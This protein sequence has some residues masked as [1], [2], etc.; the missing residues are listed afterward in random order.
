MR[1]AATYLLPLGKFCASDAAASNASSERRDR[2][3]SGA[4]LRCQLHVSGE[5]E[6]VLPPLFFGLLAL[7][8]YRPL[9]W[10]SLA[11]PP[12]LFAPGLDARTG[13]SL[14]FL[15]NS[16]AVHGACFGFPSPPAQGTY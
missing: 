2:C 15:G 3:E 11:T 7:V 1:T 6:H 12:K 8:S 14:C 13:T 4:A 9:G 10:Q 16:P 5:H